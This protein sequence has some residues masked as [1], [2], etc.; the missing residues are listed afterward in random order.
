[1]SEVCHKCP[2][3]T[4][5]TTE[6]QGDQYTCAVAWLP[7]LAIELIQQTAS[8]SVEVNKLRNKVTGIGGGLLELARARGAGEEPRLLSDG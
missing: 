4:K 1:M 3:W 5:V 8:T 7:L 6:E 2:L